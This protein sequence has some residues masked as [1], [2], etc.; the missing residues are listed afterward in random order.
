M[1]GKELYYI[2]LIFFDSRQ[3]RLRTVFVEQKLPLL[4]LERYDTV[5]HGLADLLVGSGHVLSCG[6]RDHGTEIIIRNWNG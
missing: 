6:K 1:F 3:D 5:D 2:D 4:I